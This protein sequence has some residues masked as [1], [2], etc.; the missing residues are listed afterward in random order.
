MHTHTHIHKQTN[1]NKPLTVVQGGTFILVPGRSSDA[2]MD[3]GVG[4]GLDIGTYVGAA[5]FGEETI[6][7]STSLLLSLRPPPAF[8]LVGVVRGEGGEEKGTYGSGREKDEE[9]QAGSERE[10]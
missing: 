10:R 9:R 2:G 7:L 3:L 8:P 6:A 5:C 1:K 4:V